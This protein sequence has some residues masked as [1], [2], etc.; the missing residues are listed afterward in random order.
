MNTEQVIVPLIV[1]LSGLPALAVA[2]W[3]GGNDSPLA[4]GTGLR[5]AL[6]ALS[7]F[8][9]AVGLYWAGEDRVRTYAVVIAMLVAVN[10][11]AVSLVL[12]LRRG[13]GPR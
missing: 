7:I 2:A 10:A 11:I 8:L 1:A 3:T 6:I 4:R 5:W 9:G 12:H 13:Q